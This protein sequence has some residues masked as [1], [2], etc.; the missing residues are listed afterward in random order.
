MQ[1]HFSFPDGL[2]MFI[3]VSVIPRQGETVDV[4]QINR[5]DF[6]ESEDEY[7]LFSSSLKLKIWKVH[8]VSYRFTSDENSTAIIEL[9]EKEDSQT[10]SVM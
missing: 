7:K 9:I 2:V 3:T 6:F 10:Y 1:L 8:T 5:P 4:S